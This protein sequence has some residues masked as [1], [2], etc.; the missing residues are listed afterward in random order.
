M[1]FANNI[2]WVCSHLFGCGKANFEPLVRENIHNLMLITALFLV[3]TAGHMNPHI[4]DWVTKST[5]A[6]RKFEVA[7]YQFECDTLVYWVIRNTL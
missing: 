7:T 1:I 6:P 4:T 2:V 3:W 5:H